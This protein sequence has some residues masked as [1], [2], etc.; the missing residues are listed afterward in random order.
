MGHTIYK[1]CISQDIL[2][3]NIF[4]EGIRPKILSAALWP[5]WQSPQVKKKK[6]PQGFYPL[7]RPSLP[8]TPSLPLQTPVSYFSCYIFFNHAGE[9]KGERLHLVV[10]GEVCHQAMRDKNSTPSG[11]WARQGR[12][13]GDKRR[14][15]QS[16]LCNYKTFWPR[17]LPICQEENLLDFSCSWL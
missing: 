3:L 4:T 6:K 11:L 2:T 5:K 15:K 10:Q 16:R 8:S 14:I 12:M 1:Y 9:E 17:I 7:E 13:R